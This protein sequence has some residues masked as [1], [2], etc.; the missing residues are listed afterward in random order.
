MSVSKTGK[1][2]SFLAIPIFFYSVGRLENDAVK[3]KI[4]ENI[5]YKLSKAITQNGFCGTYAVPPGHRYIVSRVHT[6]Y[7]PP[8]RG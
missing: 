1:P 7:C 5:E 4:W 8:Q 2:P 3:G 6:L